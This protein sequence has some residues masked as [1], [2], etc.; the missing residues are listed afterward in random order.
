MVISFTHL[1]SAT[2]RGSP[3]HEPCSGGVDD[4]EAVPVWG[5]EYAGDL[6]P[7]SVAVNPKL[8]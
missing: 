1:L 3:S 4:G 8:L 6:F 7:L 5:S 2:L